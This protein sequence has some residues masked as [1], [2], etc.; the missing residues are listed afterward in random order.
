[1]QPYIGGIRISNA[2]QLWNL[3][4]DTIEGTFKQGTWQ[5]HTAAQRG[6]FRCP[7][8]RCRRV[9]AGRIRSSQPHDQFP[10]ILIWTFRDFYVYKNLI[11]SI[12]FFVSNHT[13][14]SQLRLVLNKGDNFQF[15][16]DHQRQ[17]RFCQGQ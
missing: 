12:L 17:L 8:D 14:S 7:D 16:Q 5:A 2:P 1:M 15:R 6:K 10:R 9:A 13:K 3:A 11:Y 4:D